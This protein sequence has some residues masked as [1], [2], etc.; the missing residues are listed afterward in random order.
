MNRNEL[1]VDVRVQQR[2]VGNGELR[3]HREREHSCSSEEE[4]GRD[5]VENADVFVISCVKP[6]PGGCSE[7]LCR[8]SAP[9]YCCT[10]RSRPL[11]T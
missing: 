10:R 2:V 4:E 6:F 11:G 5:D 1:V 8:S 3:P 7:L 9:L